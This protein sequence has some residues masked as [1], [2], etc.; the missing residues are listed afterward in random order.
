M[1]SVKEE[2]RYLH[3]TLQHIEATGS[4]PEEVTMQ[5]PS[6][7][8]LT[9]VYVAAEGFTAELITELG[10]QVLEARGH[11]VL[12]TGAPVMAAWARNIWIGR[13]HV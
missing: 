10:T 9:T 1:R 7:E 13:A 5:P 2:Y 6:M 4:T 11:L 8:R 12:A 3:F